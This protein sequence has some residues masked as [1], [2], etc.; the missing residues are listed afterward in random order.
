MPET[1]GTWVAPLLL[2]PSMALLVISTATR[3]SQL[4]LHLADHPQQGALGKQLW[5]L[6]VALIALYS[7]IGVLAVAALLGGLLVF[8]PTLSARLMLVLSCVGVACL[9]VASAA[10]IADAIS[11]PLPFNGPN[12]SYSNATE[13]QEDNK[14]R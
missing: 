4:L 13:L 9:I 1:L 10:L 12:A 8:Q 7:G 14:I 5:Y 6:R 3:Y 2:V 11:K